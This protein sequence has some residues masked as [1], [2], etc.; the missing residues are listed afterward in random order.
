MLAASSACAAHEDAIHP[1]DEGAV[2]GLGH[3]Q[4]AMILGE[5]GLSD[6]DSEVG[7][8]AFCP[9]IFSPENNYTK[10]LNM[11]ATVEKGHRHLV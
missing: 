8:S 11:Q 6:L 9:N 7:Q 10:K 4:C 2:H 5:G 3:V 1:N